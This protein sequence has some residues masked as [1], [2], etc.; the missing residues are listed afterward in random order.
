MLPKEDITGGSIPEYSEVVQERHVATSKK[1]KGKILDELTRV[2]GHHEKAAIRLFRR[3]DE[4]RMD[5]GHGWGG[6]NSSSDDYS[7]SAGLL[8]GDFG[9]LAMDPGPLW[10]SVQTGCVSRQPSPLGVESEPAFLCAISFPCRGS[11]A[12][13]GSTSGAKVFP[14]DQRR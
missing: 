8:R 13:A 1:E 10:R 3:R 7:P 5:N 14:K 4:G 2:M 6:A 12:F 11:L 9:G